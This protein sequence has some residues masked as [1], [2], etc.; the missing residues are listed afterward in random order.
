MAAVL[1]ALMILHPLAAQLPGWLTI[2]DADGNRYFVDT[3]GKI[4]TDTGTVA[5]RKPVSADGLPFYLEQGQA[6]LRDHQKAE[7]LRMLRAVRLLADLD[8]AGIVRESGER[9][10]L[11]LNEIKKREGSRYP[12]LVLAAPDLLVRSGQRHVLYNESFGYSLSFDGPI[13]VIRDSLVQR[14][15]Y[16]RHGLLLGLRRADSNPAGLSRHDLLVYVQA[17]QFHYSLSRVQA[18][19]DMYLQRTVEDFLVKKDLR[20]E[21]NRIVCSLQSDKLAGLRLVLLDGRNGYVVTILGEKNTFAGLESEV[22]EIIG[23]FPGRI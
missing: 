15:D 1:P 17:E 11:M 8:S 13:T 3:A 10:S 7:G 20:R 23:S 6:L 2:R 4:W 16:L 12:G 21:Q 19:Y 14:H 18:Y 5:I 9:A 22:M